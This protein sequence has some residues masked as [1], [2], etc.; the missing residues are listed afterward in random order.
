MPKN[1]PGIEGER[2]LH[3]RHWDYNCYVMTEIKK[4]LS[5]AIDSIVPIG[6]DSC[7]V[8]FGCGTRPYEPLFRGRIARYIGVDVGDNPRSDIIISQDGRVPLPDCSADVLLS[9]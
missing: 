3:P 8:D 2:R 9:I 4:H 7:V 5:C 1:I 6:S